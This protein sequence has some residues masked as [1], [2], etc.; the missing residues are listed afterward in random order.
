ML[1]YY[2]KKPPYTRDTEGRREREEVILP[3]R[4]GVVLLPGLRVIIRHSE[5]PATTMDEYGSDDDSEGG[6]PIEL[7]SVFWKL[8]Y[9]STS[10]EPL[11]KAGPAPE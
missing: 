11:Q 3:Q 4:R 1:R 2:R 8:L 7:C 6:M 10:I 5:A 9:N